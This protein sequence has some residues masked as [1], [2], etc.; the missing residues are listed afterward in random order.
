MGQYLVKLDEDFYVEWSTVVD[1]PTTYGMSREEM[2][3]WLIEEYG[4][5]NDNSAARLARADERS[6]PSTS[7]AQPREARVAEAWRGLQPPV[8]DEDR[9]KSCLYCKATLGDGHDRLCPARV[10]WLEDE[11]SDYAN[12]Y[13][14]IS[15]SAVAPL[16]SAR[17]IARD[18]GSTNEEDV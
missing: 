6:R 8:S 5:A 17:S 3:Q 13:D 4:R 16:T 14:A 9:G 10:E 15:L 18:S 7:S 1:A 12:A 11:L 2:R